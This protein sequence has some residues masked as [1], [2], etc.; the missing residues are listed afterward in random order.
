MEPSIVPLTEKKLVGNR[1]R[2]SLTDNRT[3]ELW[4]G[5][6]PRRKDVHNQ[7]SSELYSI[8]EYEPGYFKSFSP[9]K[10]FDK[11]AAVEVTDF[12]AV[13]DDMETFILPTGLYAVFHYKGLSTDTSVYQYIYTTWLPASEYQLD[14]RPH[15][16]V[17][18]DKYKNNDP[19]SEE[20]IWIP[21]K[22]RQ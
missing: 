3:G 11:W 7:I 10:E 2:M 20:D 22:P 8:Q 16:E 15:F 13:P 17:L 4:R 21:I 12:E 6:L 14:H 5:F 9:D 19:A 18:G 1:L